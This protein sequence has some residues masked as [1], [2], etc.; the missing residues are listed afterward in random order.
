MKILAPGFPDQGTEPARKALMFYRLTAIILLVTAS[1]AG[2]DWPQF[3]G[4]NRDNISTET[5][6]LRTWPLK[7]P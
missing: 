6:L 2:G 1:A 7:G 4:P 5:G 3:R